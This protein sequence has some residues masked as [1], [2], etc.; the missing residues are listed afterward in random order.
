MGS[1]RGCKWGSIQPTLQYEALTAY[2]HM[3]KSADQRYCSLS[4]ASVPRRKQTQ[5]CGTCL[6]PLRTLVLV[7]I[8]ADSSNPTSNKLHDP[9]T[10]HCPLQ[11]ALLVYSTGQSASP[12]HA[13]PSM[14]ASTC[15]SQSTQSLPEGLTSDARHAGSACAV[16]VYLSY[17]LHMLPGA[18]LAALKLNMH[19]SLCSRFLRSPLG[20]T[21]LGIGKAIK[22]QGTKA[23]RS[24]IC[25]VSRHP[26][27]D[28]F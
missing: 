3:Q 24:L 25:P 17:V 20:H 7:H 26:P 14:P 9:V 16:A 1:S 27:A 28:A 10:T 23:D 6:A 18:E 11:H 8:C 13:L 21:V 12:C 2:E 15:R 5:I 22:S 4:T 19:D